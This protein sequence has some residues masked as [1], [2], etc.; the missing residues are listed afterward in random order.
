MSPGRAALGPAGKVEPGESAQEAAVRE[1]REETGVTC[2]PGQVLG[3]RVHPATRRR[4]VYVTC[5]LISGIARAVAA[6]EIAEVTWSTAG[7]L[8]GLVPDGVSPCV[9]DYLDT[10]LR[11]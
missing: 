7:Q 3:E 11:A 5:A 2:E 10:V 1:T 9:Q 4:M 8:S 6:D